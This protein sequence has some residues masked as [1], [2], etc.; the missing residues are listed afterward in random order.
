MSLR[1]IKQGI[2][3]TVQDTG[4]FGFQHLGINT[5][6]AMDRFSA[7]LA[8]ALL[9]KRLQA[10]V[11]EIHFPSPQIKFEKETIIC[12]TG[13]H[14]S[15][16]INGKEIPLH[17]PIAVSKNAV[18][19]FERSQTGARCYVALWQELQMDRWM[20]S[21]STNIKA[22]AGGWQGRSLVKNDSLP[23]QTDK[24]LSSVLQQHDLVVLPW[25]SQEVVDTRTEIQFLLG[26][27]WHWMTT[28]AQEIFQTSW[29]QVTVDADRM[30]YQLAGPELEMNTTEQLV[31]SAVSFGTVQLLPN[32]Q[33]IILMADH[34]TT[35]GYPRVAHVISAHLP[36]LAQKRANDVIR[37]C[38]TDLQTAETKLAA[39]Q[40]Y[41]QQ[42][43]MAS[44]FRIEEFI[45]GSQ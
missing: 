22:G 9:G 17:H 18:L 4:R 23:F 32:G 3:D 24:R 35:G 15:P 31:S 19:K 39:Q 6:G 25:K 43:Q 16:T 36:I 38:V 13:G 21:F 27:E 5:N 11:L 14:F 28:E 26:S 29:F 20:N 10:P 7:Q 41:L 34:Q 40:K 33:L 42:L 8:N 37:F 45:V 1:I 30:G 2:L 44:K 12:I